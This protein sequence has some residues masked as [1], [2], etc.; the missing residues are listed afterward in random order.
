MKEAR[1]QIIFI[2]CFLA[3]WQI[4]YQMGTFN[5]IV[6]P[7]LKDLGQSFIEGFRDD[8]LMTYTLYSMSLLLRRNWQKLTFGWLS[9]LRNGM[10]DAACCFWI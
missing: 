10:L 5:P 3:A 7:S 6:F 9:A 1:T 2:I 4:V 8:S